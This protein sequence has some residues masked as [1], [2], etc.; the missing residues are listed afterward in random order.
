MSKS[1]RLV[2]Q[3]RG[4]FLWHYEPF[5]TDFLVPLWLLKCRQHPDLESVYIQD[6]TDQ[7]LGTFSPHAKE[8]LGLDV[9]HVS[10]DGFESLEDVPLHPLRGLGTGP[11]DF[12]DLHDVLQG[13]EGRFQMLDPS[14]PKVLLIDRRTADLGFPTHPAAHNGSARRNID[15]HRE[16]SDALCGLFGTQFRNV[17]LESLPPLEQARLF[18]NAELIIGEHGA[19]LCNLFFARPGTNLIELGPVY[20]PT[21]ERLAQRKPLGYYVLGQ[22][23]VPR[24]AFDPTRMPLRTQ[25]DI[26]K[27]LGLV[28]VARFGSRVATA[29]PSGSGSAGVRQR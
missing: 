18:Y 8:L 24:P 10:P 2:S 17:V 7:S 14:Y 27:L 25:V 26:P 16:V 20:R 15:K 11:Y 12:L 1:L 9:Y 3:R 22:D 5:I 28:S 23:Q 13:L 29:W 4:G 21:F 6:T 19:G